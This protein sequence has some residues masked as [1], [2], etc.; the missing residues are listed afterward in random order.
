MNDTATL[1]PPAPTS[2]SSRRSDFAD[3]AD[4]VRA[5][6]LLEKRPGWYVVRIVFTVAALA[7]SIAWLILVPSFWLQL[8]NAVFLAFVLGQVALLGHDAGHRQVSATAWKNATV[9]FAN[10]L[11]VGGSWTWWI[12]AHDRHHGR[13]N[14]IGHDPA[15]GFDII[16]MTPEQAASKTGFAR[17]MVRH[18]AFFILPVMSLYAVSYRIDS[19]RHVL[20]GPARHPLFEASLIVL[21]AM[22]W[23]TGLIL[24]LGWWQAALFILLNQVVFGLYVASIFLPNHHGMPVLEDDSKM[25][26]L[27]HQVL[28]ARNIAGGRFTD[29]WFGGLNHQIEHHLFPN[30]PRVNLR[31]IRAHVR[32]FCEDRDIA[33]HEAGWVQSFRE[34]FS[35][36]HAVSKPLRS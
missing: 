20:R 15:T 10:N 36:L 23:I 16:A 27:H 2:P 18:Q 24:L 21:H 9:G 1:A 5:A 31:A 7:A 34:V 13:P 3:L 26:F 8:P 12:H 28:T 11:I 4:K 19:V 14:Q 29:F 22:V 35:Y 25:D 33:Y 32:R 17:F 30:A 6:G